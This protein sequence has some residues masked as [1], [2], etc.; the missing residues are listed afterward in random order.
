MASASSSGSAGA[1]EEKITLPAAQFIDDVPSYLKGRSADEA[2]KQLNE[3]HQVYKM[4]EQQLTHKRLRLMQ[5]EPEIKKS[6]DALLVLMKRQEEGDET[7]LDFVM[8]DQIYAKARIAGA[9]SVKLWLGANVMLEYPFEE[10]REL[11]KTNLSNCRKNLETNQKDLDF[12]K[13]CC[14][15]TEVSIARIYN[16]DISQRRGKGGLAGAK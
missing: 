12:M 13:D 5:K 11:L 16:Y 3:H 10:A 9:D 14:T 4:V 7:V 15:T 8:A 1:A 6:L 2:I